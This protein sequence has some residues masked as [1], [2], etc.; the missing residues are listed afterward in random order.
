MKQTL[1]HQVLLSACPGTKQQQTGESAYCC[2]LLVVTSEQLCVLGHL[3]PM[4]L[5][6]LHSAK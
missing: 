3:L 2:Y 1:A 6:N 4:A 5:R